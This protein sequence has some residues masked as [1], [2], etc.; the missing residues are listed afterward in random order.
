MT[1]KIIFLGGFLGAGK[2]TMMCKLAELTRDRGIKAA[3]ITN[4]QAPELVDTIFIKELSE[5]VGEISGSCFCCNFNGFTEAAKRLA[6][7][8]QPEFIFAEPVGSCTD[9]SAT[10]MQPLKELYGKEMALAPLTV[11]C[12][13]ARMKALLENA[14]AGMHPSAA[15]IVERQLEEADIIL[16]SKA[17]T[18]EPAELE[19]LKNGAA[20][21][22]PHARIMAASATCA[23]TPYGCGVKEWF[24]YAASAKEAGLRIAEVDY[25][26]YAEGEAALGWLNAR[27]MLN[28]G[29]GWDD[30]ASRLMTSLA[31]YFGARGCAVG[32]IKLILKG[33]GG[34][35]AANLT[36]K[37]ET[38]SV[39]GEAGSGGFAEM[40]FNARVETTPQKL[41]EAVREKLAQ[42]CGE[43]ITAEIVEL[44][45]LQPGRPNPTHRYKEAV[46]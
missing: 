28:G 36:G 31:E 21:R 35:V 29:G 38:L 14:P 12:D 27:V 40:I 39:R 6:E 19:A 34:C 17:D 24:D 2:T 15:Y 11:L 16:I 25:D 33:A 8:H 18:A 32:H 22:W 7:K 10:I 4:D 13:A 23:C 1:A 45:S 3:F 9:L 46:R 42:A 44:R 43:K 30:F 5:A 41:E 26:R 37:S 20:A